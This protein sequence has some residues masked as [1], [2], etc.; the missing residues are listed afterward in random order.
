MVLKIKSI[1]FL[2]TKIVKNKIRVSSPVPDVH[3]TQNAANSTLAGF[4]L[5]AKINCA[6]FEIL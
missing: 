3:E 2:S 4:R 6:N 1:L 5:H